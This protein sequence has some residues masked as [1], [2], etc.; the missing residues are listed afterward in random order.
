[1]SPYD[2][3]GSLTQSGRLLAIR[4]PL[5]EDVFLLEAMEGEEA[6]CSLFTFRLRV[7]SKRQDVKPDELVGRQISWTLE[8]P[9]GARRNWSGVVGALEV[10]HALGDGMRSYTLTTHPWL[11]LFG[12]TADCRIFQN[13]TTLQ[14]LETIFTEAGIRDW[15]FAPVTGPKAVRG[16]C[17]QYNET[18]LD[19]IF[20]LLEE[21]G[22]AWWFRHEPGQDGA[23]PR[24][25]LV[26]SDGA[27][28]WT[29]GEEPE[30]RYTSTGTDL[31]DIKTWTRRYAFKPGRV[32]EADWNFET[33]G[34][35]VARDQPSTAPIGTSEPFEIYRWGG[36]FLDRERADHVT[37]RRI[38]THE[39]GFETVEAESGNRRIH[40]GQRFRL[41]GHPLKEENGDYAVVSVR[42][43]AE[44]TTYVQGGGEQGAPGYE[45]G[46]VVV[47]AKTRWVPQQKT[48]HPRID[49]VQSAVVVGPPGEEIWTD[50]YGRIQ[51]RF[52]WDRRAKGRDGDSC[53]LRVSQ[54]WGGRSW[55]AQTI[56][57]IGMEVLVAYYEGDPDKP[58]VVGVVPNPD[59][60]VP[61]ALPDNK[62]KTVLRSNTHKGTGFNEISFEDDAGRENLFLHAQKDRAER[63][64]NNR[65]KRIDANEVASIGAHRAVEV[66]GN[67]KHEIGGSMNLTVGGTGAGA[68]GLLGPVA[69]LAGQTAGLLQQAGQIAGVSGTGLASFA[70]TL[71]SSALGFLGAGGLLSREGVVAGPNPRADQGANLAASGAGIGTDAGSLF[72]LPGIM[73]TV[74]G[75]FKSDTVGVARVEQVGTSKVTNVGATFLT[76]VGKAYQ[77]SV[78][79]SAETR[80]GKTNIVDVGETFEITAGE[81]FVITVGQTRFQM[82]KSG[83]VTIEAPQTTIVKGGAAQITVGPGPI[84]YVPAMVP[85]K[86]PSPPAQCLR[87]MSDSASPFVKS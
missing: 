6:V 3:V 62:T 76:S 34:A 64:L 5:G 50:Q 43:R 56:P 14:I 69:G 74:V 84:L 1:M 75:S 51:V 87:R 10:G 2:Y 15:D 66:G 48:P 25:V 27:H 40:P 71:A 86:T 53:W 38:E 12:H 42:H 44:D 73:N 63:V 39:A 47:P 58:M 32:A 29:P 30:I 4:T 82:D 16:Y 52:P 46:F 72:P 54:P 37:R 22:W 19:F 23:A 83:I 41:F 28:A 7:R 61:Y 24:H 85:G 26:V 21:E 17:V 13:Q 45:N 36:R 81:K 49:G 18:D 57:R 35:P 65:T 67:Q 77:L 70:T 31:N 9:G 59:T 33:P 8:L 11:W 80:V 68:L 20:R 79:E 78:G 55:G 60:Y